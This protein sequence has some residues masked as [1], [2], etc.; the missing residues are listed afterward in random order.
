MPYFPYLLI[1]ILE[2]DRSICQLLNKYNSMNKVCSH[3]FMKLLSI[4]IRKNKSALPDPIT[5]DVFEKSP[6]KSSGVPIMTEILTS[7]KF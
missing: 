1:L 5:W 3:I 4:F 6:G 2:K 7:L